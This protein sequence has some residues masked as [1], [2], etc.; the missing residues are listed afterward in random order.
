MKSIKNDYLIRMF[1]GSD[2]H[3][4]P[5]MTNV[6][7]KNGFL[8]A[9]DAHIVAKVNADLCIKEYSE[10]EKYPS[11]DVIMSEHVSFEK[12]VISVDD[13]FTDLMK[14]EVC[15]KPKMIE[16][17][18]CDGNG[19]KICEHCD[20]EYDCKTCS[21][22][23]EVKGSEIELSGENDCIVFNR[24]YKLR[25]LDMILKTAIYLGVKEIEISNAESLNGNIFYVGDFTILLMSL[26]ND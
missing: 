15:F 6:C 14:I 21:G 13:F 11:A 12:K 7:L 8:Y 19:T 4:R 2:Y 3:Y 24:R 18:D 22:T 10:I 23:G 16:C 1:T 5:I 26:R 25:Y 20:S 9:T 17:S